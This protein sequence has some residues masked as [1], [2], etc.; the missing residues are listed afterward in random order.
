MAT[1]KTKP[2]TKLIIEENTEANVVETINKD[3][4][5]IKRV[6][7]PV[8]VEQ[9]EITETDDETTDNEQDNDFE[10]DLSSFSQSDYEEIPK[11][12]IDI[13]FDD[14]ETDFKP[15]DYFYAKLTRIPDAMQ[16]SFFVS[17]S[18]EMP[19]GVFQFSLQDRFAFIPAI[20]K[21]NNNSGGRFN[22]AIF[23]SEQ[24]AVNVFIGYDNPYSP[25]KQEIYKPVG[26]VNVLIPN[27]MREETKEINGGHTDIKLILDAMQ[28]NNRQL[29]QALNNRPQQSQIETLLLTKAVDMITSP[30]NNNGGLEEKFMALMMMPQVADRMAKKMFPE[31]PPAAAPAEETTIDK[32]MKIV[33]LPVVQG[34]LE[35]VG[36][37]AEAVTVAKLQQ[38]QPPQPN[39]I[40]PPPVINP[41]PQ[42]IE[43]Q[44]E[45]DDDM[46][47]VIEKI[48]VELETESEINA[49]N[50]TIK[51]LIADYPEHLETV[52][53][54]CKMTDF[55]QVF[56]MLISMTR[57]INPF[58]FAPFIDA[59]ATSRNNQVTFNERGEKAIKRLEMVYEYLRA[60]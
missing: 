28:E 50:P 17:C 21:R 48:I 52:Q 23:N 3:G 26:A 14:L 27:P 11:D 58:P 19:L 2:K 20:Q 33:S 15:T 51:E 40:Q 49:D 12:K 60:N 5:S 38:Q 57:K 59:D 10:N 25:R 42:Q 56:N 18:S 16:D 44:P 35:R 22:I 13:I 37:I 34:A 30:Q 4:D 32:I 31:P 29:M 54:L 45:L 7:Y 9:D 39:Q 6:T 1:A 43:E 41:Q 55:P 24:K 47:I 36:D 53:T 8:R 46:K